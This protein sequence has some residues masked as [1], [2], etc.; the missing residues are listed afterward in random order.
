[1]ARLDLLVANDSTLS[2]LY[3]NQGDGTFED[4]SYAS[5]F[6]LNEDGREVAA[7]GI[8]VG[9]Y[10]NNGLLDFAITDFSD[11]AKLLFR[12]DGDASF[13]EVSPCAPASARLHSVS[14]LGR[15]LSWITTTMDGST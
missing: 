14:R 11:E 15:R 8:A 2:Y 7:M 6:A 9:D 1:M 13:T 10:M 3:L 4:A 5:G 12:N